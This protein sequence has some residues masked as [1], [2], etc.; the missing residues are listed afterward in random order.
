MPLNHTIHGGEKKILES[1]T[2][3]KNLTKYEWKSGYEVCVC[4][5]VRK[6]VCVEEESVKKRCNAQ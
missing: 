6:C 1:T 3:F 4:L 5:C 2:L